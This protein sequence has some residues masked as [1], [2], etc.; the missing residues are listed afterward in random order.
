MLLANALLCLVKTKQH[1]LA[2]FPIP[3]QLFMFFLDEKIYVT[4]MYFL[5]NVRDLKVLSHLI[6]GVYYLFLAL[7][8]KI[9]LE[10]KQQNR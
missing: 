1:Y 3:R 4:R 7:L 10:W 8:H 2:K 9:C 6:P 5:L